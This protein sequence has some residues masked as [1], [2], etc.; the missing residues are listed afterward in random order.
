MWSHTSTP[1]TRF[2]L[3]REFVANLNE[4]LIEME[5]FPHSHKLRKLL[6]SESTSH[7]AQLSTVTTLP[8]H[9]YV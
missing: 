5:L 7:G 8:S 3:T 9:F 6:E 1:P 2:P 4:L